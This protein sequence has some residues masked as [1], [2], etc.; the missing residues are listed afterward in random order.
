[1]NWVTQLLD[2]ITSLTYTALVLKVAHL[3]IITI[4]FLDI[5][6]KNQIYKKERY[7]DS[8]MTSTWEIR[9]TKLQAI[10][11]YHDWI[12]LLSHELI[13]S[14]DLHQIQIS[15]IGWILVLVHFIRQMVKLQKNIPI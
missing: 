14:C 5:G 1:M 15:W 3:H 13:L 11:W 10:L 4:I 8:V 9:Y 7:K 12:I 2:A 6:Q